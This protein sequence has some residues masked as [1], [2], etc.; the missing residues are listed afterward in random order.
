MKKCGKS[1]CQ[2]CTYVD[3]E[4]TFE[5]G[6]R[7]YFINCVFD[8]DSVGVVYLTKCERC[9]KLYVGSTIISFRKRFNNHERSLNRFGKG[10]R[11]IAG[12]RLYANCFETGRN[13][14]EDV[15]IKIIDKTNVNDPTREGF[16]AYRLNTFIP[17]GLNQRDFVCRTDELLIR[18]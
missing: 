2:I 12:E 4:R 15:E 9:A 8:C 16:F 13:G 1:P 3:E 6:G 10:G 17:Q 11:G 14:L 7:T 5:G 18:W